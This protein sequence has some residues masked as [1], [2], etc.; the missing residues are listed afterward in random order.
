MD[1]LQK[2]LCPLQINQDRR[3]L[4][5]EAPWLYLTTVQTPVQ[6][7]QKTTN[8]VIK[9]GLLQ[10]LCP[11]LRKHVKEWAKAQLDYPSAQLMHP[12]PKTTKLNNKGNLSNI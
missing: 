11:L 12:E 1:F 9:P 8:R 6:L 2:F 7:M 5:Q 10:Q 4:P 3:N